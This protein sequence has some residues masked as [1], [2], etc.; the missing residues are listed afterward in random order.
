MDSYAPEERALF[1]PPLASPRGQLKGQPGPRD[2]GSLRVP[3]RYSKK[4]LLKVY[5]VFG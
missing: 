4:K 3:T 1:K 2:R 5:T